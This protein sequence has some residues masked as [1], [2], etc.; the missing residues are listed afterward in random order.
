[1]RYV[2][3][4]I[5]DKTVKAQTRAVVHAAYR[6]AE[7]VGNARLKQQARW[8]ETDYPD[9]AA[10]LL[11]GLEETFTV[12]R[13]NLTHALRRCLGTTNL[14]ENPDGAVRRVT[15]RVSRYRD[16]A[17]ALRWTATGFLEAEKSF[18]RIQGVKDLW[19]LATALGR[20]DKRVDEMK[21]VA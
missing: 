8:L 7:K 12:N 6:L 13:L 20:N 2:T 16:A 10:S 15:R 19:V 9:A 18:R 11:E 17:M 5:P 1:M 21:N 4:R 3:E 14:I